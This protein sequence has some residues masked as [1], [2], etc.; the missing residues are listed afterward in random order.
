MWIDRRDQVFSWTTTTEGCWT[1]PVSRPVLAWCLCQTLYH[2]YIRVLHSLKGFCQL[3]QMLCSEHLTASFAG[4]FP[5]SYS[6]LIVLPGPFL[7]LH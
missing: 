5:F 4:Q 6:L 7:P 2:V 1:I 3:V